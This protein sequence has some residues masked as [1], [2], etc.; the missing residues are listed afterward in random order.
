MN[1]GGTDDIRQQPLP[2]CH[3]AAQPLRQVRRL[4]PPQAGPNTRFVL[5]SVDRFAAD[6]AAQAPHVGRK[7][8]PLD[9]S[10]LSVPQSCREF[11]VTFDHI[12]EA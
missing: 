5:S 12:A 4:A 8:R 6:L 1:R 11:V 3:L 9:R 2:A 10:G 7:E